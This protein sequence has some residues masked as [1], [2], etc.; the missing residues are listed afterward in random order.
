M[1]IYAKN[2]LCSYLD[3]FRGKDSR[4]KHRTNENDA[5]SEITKGSLS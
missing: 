1:D 2:I 5:S 4:Q 3:R